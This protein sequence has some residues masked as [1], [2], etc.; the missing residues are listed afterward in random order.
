MAESDKTVVLEGNRYFPPEDVNYDY[1]QRT[2][3]KSLCPWKGV[4]SYYTLDVDDL[5]NVNA[6]WTYRHPYPWIRKIADHVAFWRGV[7]IV[8]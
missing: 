8:P 1:L 2:W 7:E 4:A 5:V 6:A 3:S